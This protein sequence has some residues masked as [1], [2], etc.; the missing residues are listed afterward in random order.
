VDGCHVAL[1]RLWVT[2][3][4]LPFLRSRLTVKNQQPPGTRHRWKSAIGSHPSEYTPLVIPTLWAVLKNAR[5]L[6]L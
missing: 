3:S 4:V 1:T 6:L 2:S 5:N